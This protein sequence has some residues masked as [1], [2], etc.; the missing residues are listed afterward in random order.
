MEVTVSNIVGQ[1]IRQD[2]G[3]AGLEAKEYNSDGTGL[4]GHMSGDKFGKVAS[5]RWTLSNG[6]S[7]EF[8]Q[9][10]RKTFNEE[11]VYLDQTFMHLRRVEDG[12]VR[13]W[14]GQ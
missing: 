8:W 13:I 6:V 2:G 5:Y 11:V 12:K 10:T 4:F 7:T 3:S 1:W 9:Q 14:G